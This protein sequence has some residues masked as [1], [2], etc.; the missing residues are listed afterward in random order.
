MSSLS[1]VVFHQLDNGLPS[2]DAVRRIPVRLAIL[3][4]PGDSLTLDDLRTH[5]R[6]RALDVLGRNL[7]PVL[8]LGESSQKRGNTFVNVLLMVVRKRLCRPAERALPAPLPRLC[9]FS[10]VFIVAEH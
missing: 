6:K 4:W 1:Q 9:I 7:L 2:L 8:L 10:Q 3:N 5:L